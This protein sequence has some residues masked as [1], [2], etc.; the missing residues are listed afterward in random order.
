MFD[1]DTW[2]RWDDA[3]EYVPTK[4]KIECWAA[5]TKKKSWKDSV[6]SSLLLG[7]YFDSKNHK[8]KC[9]ESNGK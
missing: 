9:D 2:R 3:Y 1:D 6:K 4:R 7:N 8:K 5:K